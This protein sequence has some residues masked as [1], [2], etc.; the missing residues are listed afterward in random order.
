[1]AD[2][3]PFPDLKLSVKELKQDK[4]CF[5]V[6]GIDSCMA[7]AIRRSISDEVETMAIHRV[8]IRANETP[9]P[10]LFLAR[11][12]GLIPLKQERSC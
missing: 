8:I 11:R 9:M 3:E 4:I 10:D 6:D 2:T 7:N 12:L 5:D 1:M